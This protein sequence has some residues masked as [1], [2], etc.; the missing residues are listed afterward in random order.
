[1][2][3]RAWT[4]HLGAAGVGLVVGLGVGWKLW[5]SPPPRPEPY[6]PEIRQKDGS[7]VLERKP[8]PKGEAVKLVPPPQMPAGATLERL[9]SV[10]VQPR[11]ITLPEIPG[12]TRGSTV[13]CPPVKVDLALVRMPDQT[14]RVI[15]S[16]PDGDVVGGVDIP[17]EPAPAIRNFRNAAGVSFH[18]QRTY[19]V[20]AERDWGPA[21]LGAEVMQQRMPDGRITWNAGVRVGIRW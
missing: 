6:A 11:P 17:I 7:L 15:A 4:T 9:A 8:L 12:A 10:T 21:R 19:G 18:V 20:W 1:M 2:I 14:R 5:T 13:Q 16:S 3:P